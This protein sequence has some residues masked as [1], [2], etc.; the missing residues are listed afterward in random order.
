[1]EREIESEPDVVEATGDRTVN[2]QYTNSDIAI[3]FLGSEQERVVTLTAQRMADLRECLCKVEERKVKGLVITGPH[4]DMFTAGADINA[5]GDVD[6]PEKGRELAAEGQSLFGRIA[7]LPFPT[8]A[9]ISGPCVGGGFELA[10]SCKYR[11]AADTDRTIIGL[12][13][14]KLGILPGFGG[15]QRLPRLIGVR[16]A[17]DIILSGKTLNAKKAFAAGLVDGLASPDDLLEEAIKIIDGTKY[18][19]SRKLGL[20]E[21]LLTYTSIGRFFVRRGAEKALKR[22]TKGFYPAPPKALECVLYGLKHGIEKGLQKEAQELGSLIVTPEC[23]ALVKIYFLTEASKKLGKRRA[24]EVKG[25]ETFVIGAGAMGAGIAAALAKKGYTVW[26]KDRTQSAVDAGLGRIKNELERSRSLSESDKKQ[27]LAQVKCTTG[28]P[29]TLSKLSFVIEAVFEDMEIK[30][31]IFSELSSKV[32]EEAILATNTSSLS[33]SEIASV[34]VNPTR[35]VGMHFFNPVAKMPLVEI[36]M[37]RDTAEKTVALTAALAVRLG[38][39]P[40]VVRDVPGFLVNRILFPYLN[41]AMFLVMDGYKIEDIDRAA[42]KFGMPMGPIRL[43]DEVGLDVG[44]HVAEIMEA[45]YGDRMKAPN[46][47]KL[48]AQAGRKGRKNGMGFYDFKGK[49]AVPCPNLRSILKIEAP[50]VSNPSAEEISDRLFYPV[51]NEAVRC[52]DEGVAGNPGREAACQVDLGSVMGFGFPPFRG[53]ILHYADSLTASK[54]LDKLEWLYE[55]F[56]DRF[57]PW[58]GIKTRAAAHYSFYRDL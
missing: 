1:M 3:I 19:A 11:I 17:L 29:H 5:I 20:L 46:L 21:H 27:A 32:N 33:V 7:S 10:L 34:V 47:A 39:Y 41:E 36:V 2:L 14:T 9:A 43:L 50:V 40:I 58:D 51:I 24:G 30:K 48:M 16:P 28:D 22:K 53:G 49:K 56:G 55:R 42:L 45:G 15:T 44:G 52:L 8:V 13:E 4:Q 54:V 37:G 57:K 35:V 31:A 25:W 6:S 38:K 12:P 23:K 26:L 18:I